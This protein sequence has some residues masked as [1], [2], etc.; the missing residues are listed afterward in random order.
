MDRERVYDFVI[1][2]SGFGGSV[3][4]LRLSEKGYSVLVLERGKWFADEDLPKNNWDI[5]KYIWMPKLKCYGILEMTLSKGFFVYHGSGVGG[6]SLV[7][8]ATLMEPS[9]DFFQAPAWSHLMDWKT[10]LKPY[11]A[12]AKKMLGVVP[13][14]KLYPVDLTLKTVAEE[15]GQGNTFRSTEVG[16]YFNDT[17]KNP[18]DPYFG[19]VG[20]LR[21]GCDYCGGCISGCKNNAKNVLTKNYLYFALK[22]GAEVE[23]ET[24]VEKIE[25]VNNTQKDG[26]RYTITFRSSISD[27]EKL[28]GEVRSKN[29]VVSAGVLGTVELLLRSRDVYKTLPKLSSRLGER[30]RTNSEAFLGAFS[31]PEK[32]NH[33]Q[34]VSISSIFYADSETQIEPVRFGEDSSLLLRLLSSPIIEG[35]PSFLVRLWRTFIEVIRHFPEFYDTK[36]RKGLS[37]RGVAIMVMQAKDNLMRLHLGKNPY[38]LNKEC[39]V[40]DQDSEKSVPVNIEL[41]EIVAKKLAEKLGGYASGSITEGLLNVPMTAHI[42]GGCTIGSSADEGVVDLA[43]QVHNYPGLYVVD[44]SIIPANPGVNPSLT[45]TALAEYAMAQIP[46]IGRE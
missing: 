40:A 9:E 35:H 5:R 19:G 16:I 10:T 24:L 29:V 42:L 17:E 22:N 23:A 37:R 43:C 27:D 45:I 7:Y 6:G 21:N 25:P 15:L 20:P 8:A 28:R 2:G 4:A 38:A 44:G 14:P 13:N 39:L 31:R 41:G 3:S 18:H 26:E 30:V 32:E 33:S 12:T 46:E 34:G 11:Y 36:F 1:I